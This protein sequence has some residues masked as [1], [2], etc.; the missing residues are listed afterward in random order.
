MG[1]APDGPRRV[2]FSG[3]NLHFEHGQFGVRLED[4]AGLIIFED[5]TAGRATARCASLNGYRG[6]QPLPLAARFS[7]VSGGI[8]IDEL[9]VRV[10]ELPIHVLKLRD[11]L[12]IEAESGSFEGR[13]EYHESAA[14][15]AGSTGT[16]A[17]WRARLSGRCRDLSLS[18]WTAGVLP[19][20]WHGHGPRIELKELTI[21]D[22]RLER[23][24]FEG[25]LTGVLLGDILAPW[26]LGDIGGELTL[27]I[28]NARLSP[29]GIE[30]LVANGFC[31]RVLL[32]TLTERLGRGRATGQADL[33]IDDLTVEDNRLCSL[34][35]EFRVEP[36]AGLNWIEGQLITQVIGCLV[37]VQW[38]TYLPM[39][40]RI[41]YTQL[42]LRAEVRDE[43]L[44][45]F[46]THGPA[47]R[48][49]MTVRVFDQELPL[50]VE[51]PM[52]IELGSL[53][54]RI[55]VRAREHLGPLEEVRPRWPGPQAALPA[56][57]PL[58]TRPGNLPDAADQLGPGSSN[59]QVTPC[60]TAL[61]NDEW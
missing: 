17:S 12:G 20:A 36:Q 8:C 5:R 43:V 51:P 35:A 2:R 33:T 7:P 13:L 57:K 10:P 22:G 44:Y 31:R 32:E 4:A 9:E 48:T 25:V 3:L 60:R 34:E 47:D 52:P 1:F 28:Q 38:P 42:G 14:K 27:R 58:P 18:E 6:S 26:G 11:L 55:R 59:N 54:D 50:I 49:I 56:L 37:G 45:L 15:Q 29:A 41:E 21:R 46:G 39:P 16:I 23:L 40:A 24:E 53:L 19:V 61:P 30:R